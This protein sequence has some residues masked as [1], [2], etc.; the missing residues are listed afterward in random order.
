MI[1]GISIAARLASGALADRL[2]YGRTYLL[3]LACAF[4]G[5]VLLVL[6]G[7][8]SIYAAIVFFGLSLGGVTTLY[9]PIAMRIYNPDKSTAIIGIFTSGL[10]ITALAAPPVATT[11]VSSTG[12]FLPVILLTTVTVL[13]A[14]VLIWLGAVAE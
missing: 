8:F 7:L 4:I 1:G 2:G 9:V 14:S 11:L 3:S 10:G 6:P 12:S 13:I 5:C